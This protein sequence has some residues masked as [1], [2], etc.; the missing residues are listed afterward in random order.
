LPQQLSST[1]ISPTSAACSLVDNVERLGAP[2]D[3]LSQ[4]EHK[5]GTM[6]SG[7]RTLNG[8]VVLQV[9]MLDNSMKTLLVEP[10]S[11]VHVRPSI[12][13]CAEASSLSAK[14]F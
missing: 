3:S 8:K 4:R 11:T 6:S 1:D 12:A 10:T 5:A 2:P 7:P 14:P 13:V 9:Y